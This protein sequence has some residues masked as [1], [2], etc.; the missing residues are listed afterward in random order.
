[1][2][3]KT[4]SE[5]AE[6]AIRLF[7][8]YKRVATKNEGDETVNM[9]PCFTLTNAD[10]GT[11][12][13]EPYF[14][15]VEQV[16]ATALGLNMLH[17]EAKRFLSSS[18]KNSV[19]TFVLNKHLRED[20]TKKSLLKI[21]APRWVTQKQKDCWE[22]FLREEP[23]KNQSYFTVKIDHIGVSYF[24]TGITT[25]YFDIL[26]A[27]PVTDA[28][29]P[30][31]GKMIVNIFNQEY[32]V[33]DHGGGKRGVILHRIF[34]NEQK[35]KKL[36]SVKNR[37]GKNTDS[38]LIKGLLGEETT[39]NEILHSLLGNGYEFLMG[40][41]FVSSIF[42][43]T[44]GENTAKPFDDTNYTDLIR[45]SRGQNDNYLPYSEDCKPG[46]RYIINTFEN[47]I[48]SLSGEGIACWVK[49]QHNQ[50]FLK[51]DQF[52][53]RFDTI[54]LQ[55]LLLALH[56]RYALVDLAQQLSK[57]EL[58]RLDSDSL[59]LLRERSIKL[60]QQR[61]D[62]ADFYLRAYF[63]QPAVLD[64]HQVFYQKLQDVLGI[65]NLLEEVQKSTEELDHIIT[66]TYL[67]EQNNQSI[68]ILEKIEDL[69][70]KQEYSAQIERTLTLVV[71]VTALPYYTYSITKAIFKLFC[72]SHQSKSEVVL[73]WTENWPEWIAVFIALTATA[74]AV[75]WTFARYKRM[76]KK[77]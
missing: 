15:K 77:K 59:E 52:K 34:S 29:A 21:A 38:G 23:E 45:M 35:D 61:K 48:F 55:L 43:R 56:Q 33:Q 71:E 7:A 1:M 70:E 31:V 54:Y 32:P 64:N 65:T 2:K 13:S 11:D 74:F 18:G 16:S 51:S 24:P 49:P 75:M 10:T 42:I 6:V 50:I 47:V 26:P 73:R 68:H 37:F 39:L 22:T 57:I 58:P 41:R 40:D 9:F 14:E 3:N 20:T 53:Q 27:F 12:L 60:R 46:G 25:I 72:A 62:V 76:K 44:K 17:P 19:K 30:L 8:F 66:S 28:S 5:F 69:T 4:E 63:R 67:H 36:Q